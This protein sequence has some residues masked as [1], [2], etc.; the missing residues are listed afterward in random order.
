MPITPAIEPATHPAIRA[1]LP[2]TSKKAS[3]P[4]PI[5]TPSQ[6]T[7]KQRRQRRYAL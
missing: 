4:V 5:P 6:R 1:K 3:I 7:I 2:R